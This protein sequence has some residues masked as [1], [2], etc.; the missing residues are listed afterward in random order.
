MLHRG[1]P[2]AEDRIQ[3]TVHQKGYASLAAVGILLAGVCLAG[4]ISWLRKPSP[5]ALTPSE[6]AFASR[7]SLVPAAMTDPA[8][9]PSSAEPPAR[10]AAGKRTVS[11]KVVETSDYC[12]GAA[13][14]EEILAA[15]RQEKPFPNKELFVRAGAVNETSRPIL[16]KF[17]SD[18]QGNFTISLLPGDYCVV[19]G[20]KKDRLKVS[21]SAKG[22]QKE[23]ASQAACLEKWRR[24]CDKTLKVGKQNL[25][26]VVIKFHHACNPPCATSG[27]PPA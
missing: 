13:P 15:L 27:P 16:Q 2:L 19:E 25:R 20:D 12:G 8:A 10:K 5:S 3:M 4:D 9:T 6:P 26:G 23:A 7:A 17:A 22:N 24:T 21:E 18:A 11:G 1:N 14:T